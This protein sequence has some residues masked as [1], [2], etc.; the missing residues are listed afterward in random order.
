MSI[1]PTEQKPIAITFSGKLPKLVADGTK[2]VTRR[3][4]KKQP[5][6]VA[7][8]RRILCANGQDEPSPIDILFDEVTEPKGNPLYTATWR[9]GEQEVTVTCPYFKGPGTQLYVKEQYARAKNS[10]ESLV[11]RVDGQCAFIDTRGELRCCGWIDGSEPD[12]EPADRFERSLFK[13]WQAAR[14]LPRRFS[15]TILDVTGLGIARLKTITDYDAELE[16]LA[17]RDEFLAIW[18]AMYPD[19]P[20]RV[21][22]DPL[23]WVVTFEL[24]WKKQLRE[25]EQVREEKAQHTIQPIESENP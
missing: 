13:Q 6:A 5:V 3:P 18:H 14:F 1:S 20:Y 17:N 12:L 2:T 19:G 11:Y 25:L 15:R 22:A 23:V 4:L 9:D 8:Q 24:W 10:D 16:G 7:G 21:D